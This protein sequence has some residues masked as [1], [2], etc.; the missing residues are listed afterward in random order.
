MAL[1]ADQ[2][3]YKD[4]FQKHLRAYTNWEAT[5]SS[6]SKRLILAYCVECGLKYVIMKQEKIFR[7]SEAQKDVS[8]ALKSHDYRKLLKRLKQ[9]GTYVFPA[10]KTNHCEDVH[11]GTY[12]EFCR[13]CIKPGDKYVGAIKQYDKTFEEIVEW[14]EEQI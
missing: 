2:R 3:D 1:R 6:A 14:I 12:H 9:A 13:Y 7:T 4:A 11:P 8:E 5:G 10:I